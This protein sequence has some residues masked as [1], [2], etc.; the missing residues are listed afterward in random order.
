MKPWEKYQTGAESDQSAVVDGPWAKY[1]SAE[2][3]P[4]QEPKKEERSVLQELGRQAGL[5]GRYALEGIGNTADFIATPVREALNAIPGMPRSDPGI[6]KVI[7]DA[8]GLPEPENS[9]E[10]IVGEASK[11]MAGGGGLIKSASTLAKFLPEAML[12]TQGALAAL[13]S[14][15]GAQAVSAAGAGAAGGYVKEEGGGPTEQLLAAL[16][17]G[18]A[19]PASIRGAARIVSPKASVDPGL[20][21]L[22]KEGVTP[23]IGQALGPKAA[24]VEENLASVPVVGDMIRRSRG[25]ANESFNNAAINRATAPIGVKIEGSGTEA[26]KQAGDALSG[27][28]NDA[29]SQVK[30]V[31]FDAKF[32]TDLIQLRQLSSGLVPAMKNRFDKVLKDIVQHRMSPQRSMLGDTYKSVDSEVGGLASSYGKSQTASEQELGSALAQLQAILKQQMV[33]SNPQIAQQLKSADE[34]WANLVRIEKAGEAAKNA[35]GVFTPA[36][37]NAAIKSADDSV[38][39]R[40]VARGTALMQDLGSS[41]QKVIGSK[42]PDSGTAGRLGWSAGLVGAGALNLPATVATG[43]GGSLLYTR[44]VQNMLVKMISE[45]PDSAKDV[46]LLLRQLSTFRPAGNALAAGGSFSGE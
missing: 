31:R 4:A 1:A 16:A 11:M 34:G 36:Q 41:A 26:I 5:T 21:M 20:T 37:L 27:V 40:A 38:R 45:R 3:S 15:P 13:T 18:I 7:S 35:G 33:R 6:G 28:Y 43:V 8:A 44:P 2:S 39:G 22:K 25:Q 29:L 10:R 46:A 14:N 19:A 23:T 30:N 12:K 42:V 17:G 9:Q 32:D 24:A